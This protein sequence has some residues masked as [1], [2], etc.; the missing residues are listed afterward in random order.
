MGF[1]YSREKGILC[2]SFYGR[3]RAL[4]LCMNLA[5]VFCITVSLIPPESDSGEGIVELLR[6][7]THLLTKCNYCSIGLIYSDRP[8]TENVQ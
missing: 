2:K 6:K 5:A 3:K 4:I 8:V 7:P 1:Y